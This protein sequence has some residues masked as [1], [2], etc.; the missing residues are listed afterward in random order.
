MASNPVGK[1]LQAAWAE[2]DTPLLWVMSLS[3]R[4][5]GIRAGERRRD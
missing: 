5:G 2:D 3:V 4:S 1:K